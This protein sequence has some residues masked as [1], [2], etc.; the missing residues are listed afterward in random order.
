M[1]PGDVR[2]MVVVSAMC[3]GPTADLR[4]M[5]K[6]YN[7]PTVHL[8]PGQSDMYIYWGRTLSHGSGIP[9]Y[10]LQHMGHQR[11]SE[12]PLLRGLLPRPKLILR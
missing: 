11:F 6:V 5:D 8:G 12:A 3:D 9:G 4:D 2:G 1:P 7:L 10:M